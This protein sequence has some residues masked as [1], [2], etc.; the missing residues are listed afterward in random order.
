[1][2]Q[3]SFK[4]PPIPPVNDLWEHPDSKENGDDNSDTVFRSVGRALSTWEGVETIFASMFGLFVESHS[5]AAERAYGA[6]TS[7]SGRREALKRAAEI[8]SSKQGDKFPQNDFDLLMKHFCR[9]AVTR[10]EIAHGIVMSFVIDNKPRGFFITPAPYNSRKTEARTLSWWKEVAEQSRA[11]P[12]KVFGHD[13]RYTS[14]DVDH[15][16]KL[17]EE[18]RKQASGFFI[19]QL[20]NVAHEQFER[21]PDT[22]KATLKLGTPSTT[23]RQ[24]S[25]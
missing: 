20:M 12:F 22:Q 6:I 18:L 15:F 10:N 11:D 16:E 2:A 14:A 23:K 5:K 13:Y 17:F 8:F 21:A 24:D 1:M 19:E 7:N 4:R 25:C 9:A 3:E